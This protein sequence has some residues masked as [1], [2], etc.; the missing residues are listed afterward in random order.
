M[1]TDFGTS[2][3]HSP[4]SESLCGFGVEITTPNGNTLF[5]EVLG[6]WGSRYPLVVFGMKCSFER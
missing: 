1:T 6:S 3:A 5:A 2:V 4:E